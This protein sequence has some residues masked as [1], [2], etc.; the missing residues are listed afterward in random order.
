[1]NCESFVYWCYTGMYRSVQSERV[2]KNPSGKVPTF[3]RGMSN[4]AKGSINKGIHDAAAEGA[5]GEV[6]Y[7]D[8]EPPCL[9]TT[10]LNAVD[11]SN[12]NDRENGDGEASA[13][14]EN[15]TTL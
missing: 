3:L 10:A 9:P 13:A 5:A 8:R 15:S 11:A 12:T 4:V 7:S 6:D 14:K 1:M 2:W